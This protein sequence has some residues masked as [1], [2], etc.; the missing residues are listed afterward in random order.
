MQLIDV[1][2]TR[3][4]GEFQVFSVTV[5][6]VAAPLFEV[7]SV[8]AEGACGL[9]A[10]GQADLTSRVHTGALTG[11]PADCS[12]PQPELGPTVYTERDK[13]SITHHPTNK[14]GH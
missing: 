2:A 7:K 13:I 12:V 1:E 14:Q 11:Q 8:G 4:L 6:D 5:F 10:L 9:H 3:I